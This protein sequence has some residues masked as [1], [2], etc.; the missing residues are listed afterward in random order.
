MRWRFNRAFCEWSLPLPWDLP[1]HAQLGC[2]P[3]TVHLPH[4]GQGVRAGCPGCSPRRR[5]RGTG[6]RGGPAGAEGSHRHER[7]R[8]GRWERRGTPEQPVGPVHP[9]HVWGHPLRHPQPCTMRLLGRPAHLGATAG[10]RAEACV[11]DNRVQLVA[12]WS[13][14]VQKNVTG[15]LSLM[16]ICPSAFSNQKRIKNCK[17][18]DQN[19]G[20]QVL[21]VSVNERRG[22]SSES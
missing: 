19:T 20:E 18:Y 11:H 13:I 9:G 2:A 12:G 7:G 15:F 5:W 14:F 17:N 6:V 22:I 10:G 16:A 3:C 4:T 8:V 1:R 21:R